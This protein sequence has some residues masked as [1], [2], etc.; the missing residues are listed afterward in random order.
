[1]WRNGRMKF[2]LNTS[3]RFE[4]V[5]ITPKVREA[6]RAAGVESGICVVYV[7]HT[8][9]A[10][11]INEHAD[12]DVALD[13]VRTLDA[14]IP[15]EAGYRHSEGNSQAHIKASIIGNSRLILVE[16]GRPVLGTWEGVFFCEFDGPRLRNVYV[17]VV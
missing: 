3:R 9:A 4:M 7:P 16:D 12:P 13:I 15:L 2:D 5:D 17:K 6:V 14:L 1:M 11:A 8:T 10:V